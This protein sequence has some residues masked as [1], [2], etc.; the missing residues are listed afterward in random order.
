MRQPVLFAIR[1]VLAVI[2]L[3]LPGACTVADYAD[4]IK[5]FSDAVTQAN[6]TE[7]T[8][9]EA[10]RQAGFNDWVANAHARGAEIEYPGPAKCRPP[11]GLYHAGDCTVKLGGLA[12]PSAIASPM[13]S[14]VRYAAALS[15]VAADKSCDSFRSDAKDL[16]SAVGDIEKVAKSGTP[17]DASAIGGIAGE[18][19]CLVIEHAEL[20]LLKSTTARANPA[21]QKLIPLI[22]DLNTQLQ[23]KVLDAAGRQL[24][25]AYIGYLG[26][27]SAAD[28]RTVAVLAQGLDQ[29]QSNP[30]GPVF[31]KLATLHQALTDDLASPAVSLSRMR[32]D[33]RAFITSAQ[34]V[35]S[36]AR[37]LATPGA[38]N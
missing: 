16:T 12:A 27:R 36:A 22:V 37:T 20:N 1:L 15:A 10:A 28:L 6:S 21:I 25:A 31:A 34:S 19:G 3:P 29:A 30:A 13:T 32:E 4:G 9:A 33:A 24:Q 17:A 26:S 23:G 8:L 14:L 11:A 35:A 5:D 7:Q 18:V 2:L 38:A